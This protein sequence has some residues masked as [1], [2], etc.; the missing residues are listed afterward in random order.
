MMLLAAVSVAGGV[1]AY[2]AQTDEIQ[3][4]SLAL[5]NVEAIASGEWGGDPCEYRITYRCMF[6]D[7]ETCPWNPPIKI[8]DDAYAE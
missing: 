8:H 6:V 5:D 3:L 4:S 7:Y 2:H 1:T